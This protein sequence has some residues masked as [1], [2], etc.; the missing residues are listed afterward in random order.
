MMCLLK[1]ILKISAFISLIIYAPYFSAQTFTPQLKQEI[2]AP[3]EWEILYKIVASDKAIQSEIMALYRADEYSLLRGVNRWFERC[4]SVWSE[5]SAS[6]DL[7]PSAAF[8]PLM[9]VGRVDKEKCDCEKSATLLSS[10]HNLENRALI[11][12]LNKLFTASEIEG[13][14]EYFI[15]ELSIVVRLIENFNLSFTHPKFHLVKKGETLYRLS[16]IY[17]VAVSEIQT[18]N[19]IGSSTQISTGSYLVIPE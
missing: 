9:L 17:G 12:A 8:I 13:S 4:Q 1:N 6:L 7:Q 10:L 14:F 16:V 15:Q 2:R 3:D 5:K 11:T 19:N 18:A